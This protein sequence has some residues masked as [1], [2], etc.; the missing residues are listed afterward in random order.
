MIVFSRKQRKYIGTTYIFKT[1]DICF[2][3]Q[4]QT[5]I[6][7]LMLLIIMVVSLK[8]NAVFRKSM[9]FA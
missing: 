2:Q 6:G 8:Q 7:T 4:Q 3:A 1:Y 5:Y 9:D